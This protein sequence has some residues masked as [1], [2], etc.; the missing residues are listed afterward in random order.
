[1]ATTRTLTIYVNGKE[2]ENNIKSIRSEYI[3]LINEQAKMT[4]GSKEY[5][6]AGKGIK[7]LKKEI[8]DHNKQLRETGGIWGKLKSSSAASLLSITAGF[9]SVKAALSAVVDNNRRFEKSLSSLS[10]L[11]GAS[12]DDIKYYNSQ[13]RENWKNNN[14]FGR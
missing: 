10:A 13:A 3:K 7:K 9:V 11:T 12:A 6:E 4:R 5:I 14:N 2:V 1:M 8:D